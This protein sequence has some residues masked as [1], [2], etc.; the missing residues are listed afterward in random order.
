MASANPNQRGWRSANTWTFV[1]LGRVLVAEY[2]DLNELMVLQM[3]GARQ[4]VTAG[5]TSIG[6]SQIN[7]SMGVND[8]KSFLDALEI[9][10]SER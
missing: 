1:D 5:T 8:A 3:R 6:S 10:R 9:Y 2:D 7:V 4:L